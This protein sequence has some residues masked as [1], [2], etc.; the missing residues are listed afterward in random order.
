MIQFKTGHTHQT[1]GLI[2]DPTSMGCVGW[3]GV[4]GALTLGGCSPPEEQR[5]D[6][7][8]PYFYHLWLTLVLL[9]EAGND[10]IFEVGHL[11]PALENKKLKMRRT[12]QD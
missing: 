7:P 9:T 5:N 1:L 3:V 12:N 4:D 11:Y 10:E 2:V 6:G 8:D